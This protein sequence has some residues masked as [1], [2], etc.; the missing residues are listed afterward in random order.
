M[1]VCC[2]RGAFILGFTDEIL[3]RQLNII[4]F[5]YF[6]NDFICKV[7]LKFS[8]HTKKFNNPSKIFNSIRYS[9]DKI[10]SSQEL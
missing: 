5:I 3:D 8:I 7:K 2:T 6:V 10:V 9:V 1:K 4:M